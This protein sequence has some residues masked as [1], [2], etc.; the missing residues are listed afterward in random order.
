MSE[1]ERELMKWKVKAKTWQQITYQRSI[2]VADLQVKLG[3]IKALLDRIES[4]GFEC[5]AGPLTYCK[6]W[7]EMAQHV[8]QASVSSET[9]ESTGAAPEV[10]AQGAS[11]GKVSPQM[12][13]VAASPFGPGCCIRPICH[14]AQRGAVQGMRLHR[15]K[16][17]EPSML[18]PECVLGPLP[19]VAHTDHPL[20]HFDRTCPA[21]IE[22][23]RTPDFHDF[24]AQHPE[25]CS[26]TM[27]VKMRAAFD[28]GRS[29]I[30]A[31]KGPA[32][33]VEVL[34]DIEEYLEQHQD[35]MDGDDG[36][37]PNEAMSLLSELAEARTQWARAARSSSAMP[38][39]KGPWSVRRDE[40][41]KW[42]VCSADF[43]HDVELIVT[44]DFEDDAQAAN[45]AAEIARRLSVPSAIGDME[46]R[47]AE[48]ERPHRDRLVIAWTKE[49]GAL[50]ADRSTRNP[51]HGWSCCGTV[52]HWM[53][54]P[55]VPSVDSRSDGA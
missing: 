7:K 30:S 11:E 6:E 44:G 41:W 20:R 16:R 28:A 50:L 17:E 39:E 43:T 21:C 22:G 48:R 47:D 13:D 23:A 9:G 1:L 54:L 46:W 38:V 24:A 8:K 3:W 53:P 19:D 15:A 40:T 52:T 18:G 12:C 4:Y 10:S 29:T 14:R 2:E 34:D 42:R 26:G 49:Y 5:E 45:Y 32:Q 51:H 55:P 25:W 35:V 27:L 36:P 37:R 33:L 31:A